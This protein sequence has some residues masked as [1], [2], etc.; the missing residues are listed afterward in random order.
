MFRTRVTAL[1]AVSLFAS[2]ILDPLALRA[3]SRSAPA[4]AAAFAA[5]YAAALATAD[6]F[7]QAWQAGDT[8]NG[9]VLLSGHAKEKVSRESLE[10]FFSGSAPEAYEIGR[11]KPVRRGHYAFPVTLLGAPSAASAAKPGRLHRRFSSIIV[12]NTGNNE[13]AVDKLP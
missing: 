10:A 12:L 7:L 2:Q 3:A 4:K 1:L 8:E 11:G 13:W 5:D 6:R 9:I